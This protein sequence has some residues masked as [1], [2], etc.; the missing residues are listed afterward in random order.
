MKILDGKKLSKQIF[1]EL[2][3]EVREFQQKYSFVPGLAVILVG[4]DPASEIYVRNK[5]R[6]CGLVGFHSILKKMPAGVSQAKLKQLTEELNADNNIHGVLVQLPLP[7]SFREEKVLSWLSPKK[8]VD[9]LTL[10]NKAL[11]WSGQ[12]RV[13][14]CTPQ[15]VIALLKHYKIPIKGK[16]AVVVGRSQIVG[17]PMFQQLLACQA[18]VTVCHSQTKNVS[19]F[20]RQADIVVVCAGKPGL[21]GKEDFKKG[22]VVV[23]V[24]IHRIENDNS[25]KTAH[26]KQKQAKLC[27]DVRTKGLEGQISAF[28]PVPG[29]VGPMTIAMLLKNCFHLARRKALP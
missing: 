11:L 7:S 25:H 8:D 5:I 18:T 1:K 27:G 21:L 24:G 10:E 4:N 15:G 16:K 6:A 22:A 2:S 23:D 13:V 12:P 29:G 28:T 14:P 3:G 9:G 19:E 20:C 17:L 26:S